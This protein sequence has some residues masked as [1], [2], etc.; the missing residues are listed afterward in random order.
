MT[1]LLSDTQRRTIKTVLGTDT[2]L[3][4]TFISLFPEQKCH[5]NA[6]NYVKKN[7]NS[8]LSKRPPFQVVRG[9]NIRTYENQTWAAVYHSNIISNKFGKIIDIT[10]HHINTSCIQCFA[11]D[12]NWQIEEIKQIICLIPKVKSVQMEGLQ[13]DFVQA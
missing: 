9:W 1:P 6:W 4:P 11:L 2:L 5:E 13:F 7:G 8:D 10:K 12:K 3:R